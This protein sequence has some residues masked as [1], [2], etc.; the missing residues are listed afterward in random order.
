MILYLI[1][2]YKELLQMNPSAKVLLTV[3][4]PKRWYKSVMFIY[5]VLITLNYHLPYSWFMRLVGLG[6]WSAFIRQECGGTEIG[7]GEVPNGLNGRQNKALN[8][9]EVAAVEFFNS[10][11]EEVRN[12]LNALK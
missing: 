11:I 5:S 10:H 4:D 12:D 3:R 7:K 6:R 1:I 9:G 2:R 8:A